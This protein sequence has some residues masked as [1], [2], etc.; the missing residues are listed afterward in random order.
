MAVDTERE[1][2]ELT[3]R[4]DERERGGDEREEEKERKE[5]HGKWCCCLVMFVFWT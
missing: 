2:R 4:V 1:R 5:G 3:E